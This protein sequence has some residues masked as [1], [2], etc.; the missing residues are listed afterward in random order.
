MM[1]RHMPLGYKMVNGAVEIQEE[2]AKTVKS[3]F[4]DY[5]AG[6]SMFDI[7]KDLPA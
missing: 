4:T 3:I 2:H 6:K 7:A 1:Q 5:L